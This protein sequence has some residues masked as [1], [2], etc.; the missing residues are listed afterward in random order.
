MQKNGFGCLSKLILTFSKFFLV[1]QIINAQLCIHVKN[2]H[3]H[4]NYLIYILDLFIYFTQT[5]SM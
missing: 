1:N 2:H 3:H 5:C 4:M